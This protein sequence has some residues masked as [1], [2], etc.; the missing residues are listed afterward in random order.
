MKIYSKILGITL[1]AMTI[2][3]ASCSN[4]RQDDA[5]TAK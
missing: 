2:G 3:M 5:H 4:E 1:G